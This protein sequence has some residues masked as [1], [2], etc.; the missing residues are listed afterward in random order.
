MTEKIE[1]ELCK[2]ESKVQSKLIVERL[3][4]LVSEDEYE[5]SVQAVWLYTFEFDADKFLEQYPCLY[6]KSDSSKHHWTV[7]RNGKVANFC[8][9]TQITTIEPV[10][11]GATWCK[12]LS[13]KKLSKVEA[14]QYIQ[15]KKITPS[16]DV[17]IALL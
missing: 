16:P 7:T 8:T 14:I 5:R 4:A 6:C 13:K 17:A 1:E 3:I 10:N 2:V 11:K 15:T 12:I 9:R